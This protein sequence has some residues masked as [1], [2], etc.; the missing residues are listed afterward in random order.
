M[1]RDINKALISTHALAFDQKPSFL[2]NHR[3]YSKLPTTD[4]YLWMV[5]TLESVSG[6]MLKGVGDNQ[7]SDAWSQAL[8]Y[9]HCALNVSPNVRQQASSALSSC[10][11]QNPSSISDIITRGLWHWIRKLTLSERD[12]AA[13]AAK[14]E[15][16][17]L[18]LV[19]RA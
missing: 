8:I 13:V 9:A 7:S 11:I 18:H 16:N 19:L 6:D 10:Y 17:N 2:L 15:A 5:R 4:D 3:V 12:N 1:A 14:T